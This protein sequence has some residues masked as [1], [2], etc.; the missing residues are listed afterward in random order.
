MWLS[1]GLIPRLFL[2]GDIIVSGLADSRKSSCV[3]MGRPFNNI[4]N[5][6]G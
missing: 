6:I 2:K 4:H 1:Q 3:R 5:I